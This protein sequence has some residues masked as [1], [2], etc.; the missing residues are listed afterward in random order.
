MDV[1]RPWKRYALR[2]VPWVAL[3]VIFVAV[4]PLFSRSSTSQPL[5]I[6]TERVA[7]SSGCECDLQHPVK[8]IAIVG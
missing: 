5:H 7:S 8:K 1:A 6:T 2:A 3:S 4:N